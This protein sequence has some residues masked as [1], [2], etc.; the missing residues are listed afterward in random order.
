MAEN[1]GSDKWNDTAPTSTHFTI[2]NSNSV[3]ENTHTFIAMLFSSV[4]GISKVGSYTGTASQLQL[5]G[6]GFTPRFL[7]VKRVDGTGNWVV[8]DTTRGWGSGDDKKI[9]IN[10]NAAQTTQDVGD[11]VSSG[12]GGFDLY[13]GNDDF[14][15]TGLSYV[16]YAHA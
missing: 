6:L 2:G 12:G 14:N 11:P 1:T 5:R 9:F 7:L 13:S 16:Y 4:T 3:N 15:N 10:S 8:F